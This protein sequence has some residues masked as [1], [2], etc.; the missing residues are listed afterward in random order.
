[1]VVLP[2]DMDPDDFP[3]IGEPLPVEFANSLYFAGEQVIDFLATPDLITTWFALAAAGVDATDAVRPTGA[4][5]IRNLRDAVRTLLTDLA[6][7]RGPNDD[8]VAT[9]N[10][11]ASRAPCHRRLG[12]GAFG[13]LE[14]TRQYSGDAVDALLGRI[15]NETVDLVTGPSRILLRRCTGP[16]CAMLFVKNHHKRRWCHESCGH[17]ARQARYYRRRK[18]ITP[19]AA[20]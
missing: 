7:D 5:S 9:I 16:G 8:A 20:D 11:A 3:I 15:A 4:E 6:L 18:S 13:Q 17:R 10:L 14:M 2:A 1:V 19:H 12:C